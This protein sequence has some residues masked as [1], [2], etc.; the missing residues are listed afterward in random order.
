MST[1]QAPLDERLE[2]DLLDRLAKSLRVGGVGKGEMASH[3]GVSGNTVGNYLAGRTEPDKATLMVWAMRCGVPYEWLKNGS[4]ETGRPPF[5]D[6]ARNRGLGVDNSGING[7]SS[8][9]T[10]CRPRNVGTATLHRKST[11]TRLPV[12]A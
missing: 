8:V 2:Y 6:P 11:V 5:N 7:G 4:L 3:L 12:A 1:S 10:S 9:S